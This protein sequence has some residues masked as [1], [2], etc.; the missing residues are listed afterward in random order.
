[1]DKKHPKSNHNDMKKKT[2]ITLMFLSLSSVLLMAQ[3]YQVAVNETHEKMQ[4]GKYE[5]TWESLRKH[6]TPD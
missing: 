4:K 6:Q 3:N 1:M 5:P 2:V